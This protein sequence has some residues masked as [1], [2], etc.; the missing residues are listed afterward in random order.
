MELEQQRP[1]SI[2]CLTKIKR[3]NPMVHF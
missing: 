2:T 1:T 3:R